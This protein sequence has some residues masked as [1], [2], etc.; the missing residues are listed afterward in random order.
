[1][2][3]FVQKPEKYWWN[4]SFNS[5]LYC[6][7]EYSSLLIATWAIYQLLTLLFHYD[8]LLKSNPIFTAIGLLGAIIHSITWLVVMPKLVP[9][10]LTLT[11]HIILFIVLISI[12]VGFS[13][14]TL[15]W[16]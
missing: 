16:F 12:W 1:M 15:F 3:P 6:I 10:K 8:F 14:F 2:E 13:F 9:F 5:R 7:R 11:L 4:Q